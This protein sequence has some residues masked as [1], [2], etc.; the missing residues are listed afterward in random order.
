MEK[1]RR[2]VKSKDGKFCKSRKGKVQNRN[3]VKSID[4]KLKGVTGNVWFLN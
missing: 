4:W 1:Y 3:Y 2:Y